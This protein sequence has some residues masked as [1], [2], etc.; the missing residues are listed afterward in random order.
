MPLYRYPRKKKPTKQIISPAVGKEEQK[1]IPPDVIKKC[2]ASIPE[3]LGDFYPAARDIKRKLTF[4]M[5]PTNSGKT[6]EA[7]SKLRTAASGA[8]YGPLRLLALEVR[9]LL[10]EQGL[11]ISLVTGELI[12]LNPEAKHI[13]ATIEML[14]FNQPTLDVVVIDEVQMLGDPQRGSTWLHAIMGAPSKEVWLLG[15][16]EALPLIQFLAKYLGENLTVIAKERLT[17]FSVATK[18]TPFDE[19][20]AGSAIIAFSRQDVLAVAGE[21]RITHKRETSVVYGALSPDV[22]RDQAQKFRDGKTE[23]VVATDAI[24]QGLNLPIAGLYFT[25]ALKWNGVEEEKLSDELVWQI[26]GRAGRFGFH[27]AG[28]VGA[29]DNKTLAAITK[30]LSK[31]PEPLAISCLFGATWPIIQIISEHLETESLASILDFFIKKLCLKDNRF[32]PGLDT[33]CIIVAKLLDKRNLTL[34]EKSRLV[35]AP[36]PMN[37]KTP[38]ELFHRFVKQVE[39][40]EELPLSS[41]PHIY[42]AKATF[43]QEYSELAVKRLTLYSWLHYRYPDVFIDLDEAKQEITLHNKAI[44]G[45]LSKTGTRKCPDCGKM[46]KWNHKFRICDDC[47]RSNRW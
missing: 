36:I 33:E 13:A 9:D 24:G 2:R 14:D 15:A 21:M 32:K 4:V 46:V 7:L 8:Y 18:P 42:A 29:T 5:G 47:Y 38:D 39:Q 20:P 1:I 11:P 41:I 31:R 34:L 27:E 35:Y 25:T 28:L 45:F 30:A 16:P 43:N 26:A 23:I 19:I 6:H 12:E 37:K 17:P 22:R 44:V 10:A 40:G 3:S